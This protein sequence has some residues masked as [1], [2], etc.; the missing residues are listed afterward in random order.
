MA[1]ISAGRKRDRR[2]RCRQRRPRS[3][4]SRDMRNRRRSLRAGSP[5]GD[6]AARCP[7]RFRPG[8]LRSRPREAAAAR[9]PDDAGVRPA[10]GHR[11]RLRRRLG[12]AARPL[13]KPG[14]PEVLVPAIRLAPTV[15][16]LRPNWSSALT[17]RPELAQQTAGRALYP[18]GQPPA[19]GDRIRRPDLAS[20]LETIGSRGPRRLLSGPC[21]ATESSK[22]TGGVITLAD[23]ERAAVPNGPSPSARRFSG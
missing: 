4:R 20:T 22:A 23:L 18:Q 3:G 6:G 7:E 13:R 21:R 10:N 8:G 12:G 11:A 17:R 5:T 14:M 19:I 15:F 16:R 9:A 1:I 2:C